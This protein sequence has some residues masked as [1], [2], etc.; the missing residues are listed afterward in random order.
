MGL[1]AY[2]NNAIYELLI[3]L[4]IKYHRNL[5]DGV[6]KKIINSGG[7]D[8]EIKAEIKEIKKTVGVFYDWV[9]SLP[10]SDHADNVVIDYPK[11]VSFI[12]NKFVEIKL[13]ALCELLAFSSPQKESEGLSEVGWLLEKKFYV[14]KNADSLFKHLKEQ[15]SKVE[16]L[17]EQ[18]AIKII[19]F[20]LK[21]L[22]RLQDTYTNSE[23]FISV[24]IAF[25]FAP[26]LVVDHLLQFYENRMNE[27]ENAKTYFLK[28]LVNHQIS[29]DVNFPFIKEPLLHQMCLK[30]FRCF[31]K[32]KTLFRYGVDPSL[33]NA[34]QWTAAHYLF[35]GA[36]GSVFFEKQDEIDNYKTLRR[37]T[38]TQDQEMSISRESQFYAKFL[39]LML[40]YHNDSGED[41]YK[42]GLTSTISKKYGW[43][44]F[45]LACRYGEPEAIQA[46][47]ENNSNVIQGLLKKQDSIGL[48]PL[49]HLKRHYSA[50][51]YKEIID[52]L[53]Q[54][55][56]AIPS[57]NTKARFPWGEYLKKEAKY[58][59]GG[60]LAGS[61]VAGI[62]FFIFFILAIGVYT[63]KPDPV[64]CSD[65]SEPDYGNP[66][67]PRIGCPPGSFLTPVPAPPGA[68]VKSKIN[69]TNACISGGVGFTAVFIFKMLIC[70]G[71][72]MFDVKNLK[73]KAIEEVYEK[74]DVDIEVGEKDEF[75][76]L[77]RIN[78]G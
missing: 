58:T 33:V 36:E 59:V 24:Y 72:R 8:G 19:N 12:L 78:N 14:P 2:P 21:L 51:K 53:Q 6:I 5:D 43:S 68:P 74:S 3:Y 69:F 17:Y 10:K 61:S 28:Q 63:K 60:V 77:L 16:K 71:N 73:E 13:H 7:V 4:L 40:S 46:L 50:N 42:K 48:Y 27:N 67:D 57:E 64:K 39:D 30:P 41:C 11:E 25:L 70:I 62:I 45:H 35:M 38:E 37:R 18:H 26:N 47:L 32:I 23:I 9:A 75:T 66:W 56:I 1:S 15:Q 49:N 31:E 22:Q 52:I 20:L 65:G 29:S 76:P 34:N 55:E 54:K 44:I